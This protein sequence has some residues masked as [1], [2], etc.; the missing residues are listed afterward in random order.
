MKD[1]NITFIKEKKELKSLS[2]KKNALYFKKIINEHLAF[3][4]KQCFRVIKFQIMSL[5]GINHPIHIENEA[6]ELSNHVLDRLEKNDY[7]VLCNYRGHA[8][9]TTYLTI[10]ISNQA[11]DLMRKKRGRDRKKE[12][13]KN[14]GILGKH[15]HEMVFV[16]GIPVSEVYKELK[17]SKGVSE[18]FEE[19]E[20]IVEKIRGKVRHN[21]IYR[22]EA[23][24]NDDDSILPDY[25]SN[26][27][28]ILAEKQR[29]DKISDILKTIISELKGEDS[30]ILRMRFLYE[31]E[32]EPKNVEQISNILGIS[33][34]AVY[35]RIKKVMERCRYIMK[36]E[37]IG[38]HDLF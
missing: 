17:S 36:R 29:K 8:K 11:V 23:P 18:S 16:Q 4:E 2:N 28:E 24:R 25:K 33:K 1:K 22:A 6:L 15:I 34:K 7:Q 5:S 31:G 20:A 30:L 9:L 27:E 3:I 19:V 21:N 37:G 38:S 35:K 32:K 14:H 12:R 26:P 13:A 10:I